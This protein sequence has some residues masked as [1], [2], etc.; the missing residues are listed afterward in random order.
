MENHVPHID[1]STEFNQDMSKS[2]RE[3][4]NRLLKKQHAMQ[5]TES[6]EP[7]KTPQER[8][9]HLCQER[10]TVQQATTRAQPSLNNDTLQL[11]GDKDALTLA[12]WDCGEI[13]TICGFCNAKMWIKKRFVQ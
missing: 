1:V 6:A 8:S 7:S 4:R 12:Q 3:R 13:D 9:N 10:Q 2:A 5:R 11:F